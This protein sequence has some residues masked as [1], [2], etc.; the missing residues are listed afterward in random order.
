MGG[1]GL[2]VP[3]PQAARVPGPGLAWGVLAAYAETA[4][5]VAGWRAGR[6]P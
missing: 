1:T 6:D 5:A 3:G 4:P 2:H